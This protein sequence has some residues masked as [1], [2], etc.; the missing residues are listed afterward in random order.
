LLHA[1]GNPVEALPLALRSAEGWRSLRQPHYAIE[2]YVLAI[3]CALDAGDVARAEEL[4]RTLEDLPPIERRR[5]LDAEEHRIRGLLAARRGEDA[6]V[7][8]AAAAAIFRELGMRYSLAVTLAEA[9]ELDE[10]RALFEQLGAR[11]WLDRYAGE[12]RPVATS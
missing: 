6:A 9:G 8:F 4:L 11:A 3:E 12:T 5:M 1:T 2:A 7:H 10:A